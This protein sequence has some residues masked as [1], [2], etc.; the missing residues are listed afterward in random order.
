MSAHEIESQY[1]GVKLAFPIALE[2]YNVG[3]RRIEAASDRADKLVAFAATVTLAAVPY[4][5]QQGAEPTGFFLLV[6]VSCFVAGVV[7]GVTSRLRGRVVTIGP[8]TLYDRYLHK[9]A[10]EFRK[11][12]IYF[13][14]DALDAMT[15]TVRTKHRWLLWSATAFLLEV[16]A[17][18]AAVADRT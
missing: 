3:E 6:A 7:F 16:L 11:D 2:A 18:L 4:A 1:P 13:A 12:I 15:A 8:R 9:S 17:L 5:I 10:W 14:G